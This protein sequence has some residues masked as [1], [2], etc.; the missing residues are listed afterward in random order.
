[1]TTAPPV[2]VL[3]VFTGPE[4]RH[5]NPLGVLL[6]TADLD[7]ERCQAI[8]QRLAFSETVFVDDPETG[9]CRIF[10][11]VVALPFA[12]HPMVGT[13]WLLA[14]DG[15]GPDALRPPAGR[16]P[17]GHD[18]DDWWV[19]AAAAWCPPWRLCELETAEDVLAAVPPTV[20]GHEVLWAWTDREVG[21]IR[22]RVFAADVGV[23]E[24][25]A[26]GSA[27]IPLAVHVGRPVVITQGKGSRLVAAPRRDGVAAVAGRVVLDEQRR[28]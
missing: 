26:T 27:A 18:G 23:V 4:G 12:G 25:E 3:R 11:P 17:Y 16:V 13:A 6:G 10:T 8:A 2:H 14:R 7:D 28:L 21:H 24:D 9:T 5:G 1:M 19:E 15:C 20:S 22:A